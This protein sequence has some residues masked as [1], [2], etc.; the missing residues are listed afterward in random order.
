MSNE[1]TS[2]GWIVL[3]LA[4]L[5]LRLAVAS[6]FFAA[7]VRK[8]SGGWES[9]S[10]TVDYFQK[11]FRETW[12]PGPMVTAH[13]FATPFVESLIVLWLLVGYRLVTGWVLMVL[14]TIS[15]AFG[16][17]VASN[18]ET[19]ANNYNYVLIGVVG[20]LLSRFDRWSIDGWSGRLGR[21]SLCGSQKSPE[22]AS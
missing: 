3:P 21:N 20:L 7:A 12:L 10:G 14:F 15:L 5:M 22:S 6:L 11:T 19:A 18:Y 9:I 2:D 8:I 1:R 13:G 4:S 16:M 17:S